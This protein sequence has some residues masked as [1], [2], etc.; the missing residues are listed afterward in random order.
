[1][2]D[3]AQT[4]AMPKIHPDVLRSGDDERIQAAKALLKALTVPEWGTLNLSLHGRLTRATLESLATSGSIP[5]VADFLQRVNNNPSAV[6]SL[7]WHYFKRRYQDEW[8]IHS[9]AGLQALL[10]NVLSL[11]KSVIYKPGERYHVLSPDYRYLVVLDNKGRRIT[12]MEPTAK[13]IQALGE[14]KWLVQ[15][16]LS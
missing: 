9:V 2:R 1:M 12:V 16:L 15:E 14:I 10:S 4:R 6:G 3:L 8:L 7:E 11:P 5:E 13:K